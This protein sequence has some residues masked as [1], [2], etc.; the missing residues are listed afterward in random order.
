[1]SA[2]KFNWVLALNLDFLLLI[3]L[4]PDVA[5]FYILIELVVLVGLHHQVAML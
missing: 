2:K 3:S 4:Q 1:M 5:D